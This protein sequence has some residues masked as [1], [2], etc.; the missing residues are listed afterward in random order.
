MGELLDPRTG[1]A[2]LAFSAWN[3]AFTYNAFRPIRR[4]PVSI[5][6]FFA[7]WLTCELALHH[8]AWQVGATLLFVVAGA[9]DNEPGL[10]G[11]AISVASWAA[12][13][14]LHLRAHTVDAV[15]QSALGEVLPEE[16]SELATK[17]P[18]RIRH[19]ARPF[20]MAHRDVCAV[21]DIVYSEVAGVKLR[22]DVYYRKDMPPGA[23]VLLFVHG[24][25]WI[26]GFKE[27]QALPMLHRMAAQGWVCI[28]VDYRLSPKATFPDHLVDVKRAIVW[29]KEHAHEYGGDPSFLA[30]SGNS[31]GA[32]L[33]A[34]AALTWDDPEYQPGF[35]EADTRVSACV[36]LYG[37]YDCTHCLGVWPGPGVV[38]LMERLVI[39]KKLADHPQAFERASPLH[40][41]RPDAP[42]FFVVHGEKDSLVPVGEGRAFATR[43]R[44]VSDAM[45]AYLEVPDGQ[46]AFEIFRTV[47]GHHTLRAIQCFLIAIHRRSG[48]RIADES[49]PSLAAE[50]ASAAS[51]SS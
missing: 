46:H 28:S 23:P 13:V 20:S 12:L 25:A 43:L 15:V 26:L 9:L 41:V 32:H 14:R 42:P 34:L 22:A 45:V 3:A 33:A 47:R 50:S 36:P 11:F 8:V 24:G 37:V 1:W 18:V 5:V 27:F 48:A 2:F 31:A 30:L 21:R 17:G 49:V 6:A 51:L 44:E 38:P 4:G 16:V 40:R 10:L 7:G 35:E 19:I 39:K 29:T